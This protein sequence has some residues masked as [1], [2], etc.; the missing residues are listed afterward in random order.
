M[1]GKEG[2][3]ER[4][5]HESRKRSRAVG[6]L[7]RGLFYSC[8]IVLVCVG[9]SV[10]AKPPQGSSY[11]SLPEQKAGKVERWQGARG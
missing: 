1:G 10:L 8:R 2:G 9:V 11:R 7:W 3:R 4:G 6:G 5:G